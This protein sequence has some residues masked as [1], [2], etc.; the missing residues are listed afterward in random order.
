MKNVT[1]NAAKPSCKLLLTAL[2]DTKAVLTCK[3]HLHRRSR[4]TSNL[5]LSSLAHLHATTLPSCTTHDA[6][7]LSLHTC[8]H[9]LHLKRLLAADQAESTV[10]VTLGHFSTVMFGPVHLVGR[11]SRSHKLPWQLP[12]G[13]ACN[14]LR[15]LRCC[16]W[17]RLRPSWTLGFLDLRCILSRS[18]LL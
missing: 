11:C 9:Y 8:I 17:Y 5:H 1:C 16:L 18:K 3:V 2:L 14:P 13:F 12:A 6:S 10:T 7:C 4:L 15:G